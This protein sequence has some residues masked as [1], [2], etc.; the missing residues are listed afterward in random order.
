MGM[1]FENLSQEELCDLMRG[2]PEGECIA[3]DEMEC[4]MNCGECEYYDTGVKYEEDH[5]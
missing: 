5:E 4:D 3:E 1:V 2:E